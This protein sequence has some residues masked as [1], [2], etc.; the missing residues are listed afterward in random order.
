MTKRL[1]RLAAWIEVNPYKLCANYGDSIFGLSG[2]CWRN[3]I[4]TESS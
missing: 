1:E 4:N 3:D 2:Q